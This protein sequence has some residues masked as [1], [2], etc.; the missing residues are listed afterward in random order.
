MILFLQLFIQILNSLLCIFKYFCYSW[1][2][3]SIFFS[4]LIIMNLHAYKY[5]RVFNSTCWSSFVH[6]QSHLLFHPLISIVLI[7]FICLIIYFLCL[8]RQQELL[9]NAEFQIQQTE[10][11]VARGLGERSDEEKKSLK[12]VHH[13]FLSKIFDLL[14]NHFC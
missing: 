11:K 14:E 12:Y 13:F 3:S 5:E 7:I 10:R 8:Y 2:P 6:K 1:L 9:Y 4:E